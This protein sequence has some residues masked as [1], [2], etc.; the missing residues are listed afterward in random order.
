MKVCG[1]CCCG[2]DR[3]HQGYGFRRVLDKEERI[4]KLKDYARNLK[5]ELEM[6]EENLHELSN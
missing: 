5:K 2:L 1:N 3:H 6:V 4:E